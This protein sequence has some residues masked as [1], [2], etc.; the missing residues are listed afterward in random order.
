MVSK[1]SALAAEFFINLKLIYDEIEPNLGDNSS[2]ETRNKFILLCALSVLYNQ[3]YRNF[4]KKFFK[5]LWDMNKKAPVLMLSGGVVCWFSNDFLLSKMPNIARLVEKNP[6]QA[7]LAT[8]TQFY[9]SKIQLLSKTFQKYYTL[10]N[11]WLIKMQSLA[12][13]N[14]QTFLAY[15]QVFVQGAEV[16]YFVSNLMATVLNLS[17]SLEA[18]MTKSCVLELC[19]FIELLKVNFWG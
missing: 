12:E 3:L 15:E 17:V 5:S 10:V 4:D 16:S 11:L 2:L 18:P 13:L 7:N 1:N 9:Q 8:K 6:E 14:L 19:R